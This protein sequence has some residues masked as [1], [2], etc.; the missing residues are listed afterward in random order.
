MF[1]G[2][3]PEPPAL[4]RANDA[5]LVD[6]ISG[7]STAASAADG[8]RL[9]AIAELV[10]RRCTDEH[11][12]WACDDWDATAAEI[13]AALN[14][15]HGR[16]SGLMNLAITLRD[17]FPKVNALLLAGAITAWTAQVVADRT[18][19]VFD[20]DAVATL[21]ARIAERAVTWGPLSEYKL[22]QALDVWVEQIDPGAV[23]RAGTNARNRDVTLG[24][25]DENSGTTAL[26]GRLLSTDAALLGKR[27]TAMANA[28]C[29]ADP[30]T[31]AQRR[32]DALGALGAKSQHLACL[33][34]SPECP[35]G[36]D[37]GRASSVVVHVVAEQSAV[38][39]PDGP[40]ASSLHGDHPRPEPAS[41]PAPALLV[42]GR[43][44]IVPAPLL[45]ELVARGAKVRPVIT[46]APAP[47][48]H[49]RPSAKLAEFVRIRDLTCRFPGCNRP[50]F[51]TDIDHTR[52]YP[53]G[54]THA[55]NNGCYCRKH[56]LLKTFW[57]GWSDEQLAD[58]TILITTPTGHTYRS[59]PGAAL[60]FPN[61][62]TLTPVPP[63]ASARPTPDSFARTLMMP[64]RKQTRAQARQYR[65]TA[66][67]ALNDAAVAERNKPPP[68]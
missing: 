28:V 6:A 17:R 49:Y 8:R 53:D 33:C 44:G 32:A 57:P 30:R 41:R 15:S 48:P 43:G 51:S 46:P 47:E 12:D 45:A 1:D 62:P 3:L 55:G 7:W 23:R 63:G 36:A 52:P 4:P 34:G 67:R 19:L 2:S 20:P 54:P 10:S 31:M 13:A 65:I 56:H 25:P 29:A 37:D 58:G 26:W 24:E 39:E 64:R 16:A 59:K 22:S 42:E 27:L 11:P 9:A 5:A 60:L 50:A 61:W 21:D 40:A 14:L 35:A 38:A 66:E 18:C 68:Y